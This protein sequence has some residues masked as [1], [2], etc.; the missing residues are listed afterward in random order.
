[1]PPKSLR[2]HPNILGG[3]WYGKNDHVRFRMLVTFDQRKLL[4]VKTRMLER[5]ERR[6]SVVVGFVGRHDDAVFFIR[7]WFAV[8]RG[9]VY[10]LIY[11]DGIQHETAHLYGHLFQ[12]RPSRPGADAPG[13]SGH[14]TVDRDFDVI[15]IHKGL[16]KKRSSMLFLILASVLYGCGPDMSAA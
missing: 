4:H 9:L 13:Q 6:G 15:T 11:L 7:N 3:H 8:A 12:L 5:L 16:Q 2:F 14:T 1:M 10:R